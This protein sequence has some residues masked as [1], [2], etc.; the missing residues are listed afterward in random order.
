MISMKTYT[1]AMRSDEDSLRR[2]VSTCRPRRGHTSV[3]AGWRPADRRVLHL[4]PSPRGSHLTLLI[5]HFLQI[6]RHIP[7]PTPCSLLI[8]CCSE[9][10][11]LRISS[12]LRLFDSPPESLSSVYFLNRPCARYHPSICTT[13]SSASDRPQGGCCHSR[14]WWQW[15][16]YAER[17]G[18]PATPRATRHICIFHMQ[19]CSASFI[20][21]SSSNIYTFLSNPPV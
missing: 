17:N 6:T 5:L 14:Q 13:V 18:S 16:L 7:L 9:V 4:S 11:P 2:L 12:T 21:L 20:L 3:T 19:T 10:R 15:Y 8:A 1:H